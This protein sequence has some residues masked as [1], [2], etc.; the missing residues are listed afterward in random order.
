ME[1]LI[2]KT[3]DI[4]NYKYQDLFILKSKT[5]NISVNFHPSIELD[6][7]RNYV[8]GLIYFTVFNNIKNITEKNNQIKVDNTLVKLISG[9]YTVEKINEYISETGGVVDNKYNVEFKPESTYNRFKLNLRNNKTVDFNVENSIADILGFEKKLY[10][11]TTLAPNRANIEN[12]IDSINVICNLANGGYV[13][14]VKKN[15]IYSIPSFTVPIGYRIN[16]KPT[17]VVYIPLNRTTIDKIDLY[18]QDDEGRLI[19]FSGEE[20]I[21]QLHINQI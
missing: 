21:V 7:N 9:S 13:N 3:V 12:D 20:I 11:K 15:I 10:N 2:K 14:G 17:N 4:A 8:I 16:E 1:E 18:V 19:D 6:P 5:S